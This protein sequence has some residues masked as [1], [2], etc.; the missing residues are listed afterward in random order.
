MPA[1]APWERPELE[2]E[3]EDVAVLEESEEEVVVAVESAV[4][5]ASED[6]CVGSCHRMLAVAFIYS[7]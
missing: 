5:V 7:R 3:G 6:A 4:V 1:A 2:L